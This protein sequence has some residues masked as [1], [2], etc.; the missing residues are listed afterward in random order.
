MNFLN[1]AF[2]ISL[3]AVAIPLIVHFLSRRRVPRVR[4]SSLDFLRTS[5]RR[6]MKRINFRRIL[7]LVLRMAAVALVALAFS[8]PVIRGAVV[9]GKAPAAS[10]I[11]LDRSYSMGLESEDGSLLERGKR[12]AAAVIEESGDSDRLILAAVDQRAEKLFTTAGKGRAFALERLDEMKQSWLGT[13]LGRGIKAGY[14]MLEESGYQV[15]ELYLISDFRTS[16]P[17]AA[18]GSPHGFEADGAGETSLFM[19]PVTEDFSGNLAILE[20]R[21]PQTAIHRGEVVTIE[22]TILNGSQGA[23]EVVPASV[24]VEGERLIN[25]QVRLAPGQRK[26]EEFSFPTDRSG[27]LRGEVALGDDRLSYDNR[28]LFVIRVRERIEVL[29]VGDERFYLEKALNPGGEAGDIELKVTGSRSI[30][31]E[32]IRGADA[33]V[34][35]SGPELWQEDS[36]ILLDY[37][38]SG[39]G[40]VVFVRTELMETV[41]RLSSFSLA[42]KLR[43]REATLHDP[44]MVPD[45]LKPF[46]REDMEKLSRLRFIIE[47]VIEGVPGRATVL[48]FKDGTPFIWEE[49]RG[50]G[51]LLFI[52]CQ[53][54]AAGG[55]LVLSPYF[56]PLV[57]QAVINVA[58]SEVPEPD[59]LVGKRLRWRLTG[60]KEVRL[61]FDREVSGEPEEELSYLMEGE[62]LIVSPLDTPGFIT[63]LHEEEVTG[64]IAVNPDCAVESSLRYVRPEVFADSL[65][66][67]EPEVLDEEDE[68]TAGIREARYGQEITGA[69][70][71]AA[72]AVFVIELMVAQ[73]RTGSRK[74]NVE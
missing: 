7:L 51:K 22:V 23:E 37:I 27:W 3:A 47:P 48:R 1:P 42:A 9:P 49:R 16:G 56:L 11:V 44:E 41:G 72:I 10:C 17:A 60:E 28:R 64:R 43:R 5:Q 59:A 32:D 54:E 19:V 74:E 31:S 33:V 50:Q 62:D 65:G 66:L 35:G 25:R 68:I 58:E 18:T 55:E 73:S 69:L 63:L 38:D 67:P 57:Q 8:R 30:T 39:G 26:V 4:F 2:L 29:L 6:S 21:S 34:L 45:L 24:S 40:A 46:D 53:P 12:V 70:I 14:R 52:L 71:I 20:I 15:R 36:R 61:L 13:D